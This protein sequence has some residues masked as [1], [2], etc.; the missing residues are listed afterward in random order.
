MAS[1]ILDCISRKKLGIPIWLLYFHPVIKFLIVLNA[2]AN[3]VIYMATGSTYRATFFKIVSRGNRGWQQNS[4]E[5]ITGTQPMTT[6]IIVAVWALRR[7]FPQRL[8]E[9]P[10]WAFSVMMVKLENT[11]KR[12]SNVISVVSTKTGQT[13]SH[14]CHSSNYFSLLIHTKCPECI[15]KMGV[16]M[17]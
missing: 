5:Q 14:T 9:V 1:T 7:S 16:S 4:S 3:F 17:W 10:S 6:K 8:Q 12:R 11:R 15:Y 2:S 13:I